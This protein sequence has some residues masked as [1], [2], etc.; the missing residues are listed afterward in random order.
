M[1]AMPVESSFFVDEELEVEPDG[2]FS[3]RTKAPPVKLT[4]ILGSGLGI[5]VD[6]GC[7][8]GMSFLGG[9]GIFILF[10]LIYLPFLYA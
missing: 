4:A 5:G 2:S 3:L 1:L 7:L 10:W 9:C 6:L 8:P